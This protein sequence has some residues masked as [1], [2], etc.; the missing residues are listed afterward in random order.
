MYS[1]SRAYALTLNKE[2]VEIISTRGPKVSSLY[3]AEQIMASIHYLV[4][5]HNRLLLLE[6]L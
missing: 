1:A 4:T 5:D 6:E 3:T 2:L